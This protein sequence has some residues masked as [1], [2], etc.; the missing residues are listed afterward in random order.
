[1]DLGSLHNDTLYQW[2]HCE[3]KKDAQRIIDRCMAR[4]W[5]HAAFLTEGRW[6]VILSSAVDLQRDLHGKLP[7][8]EF[9]ID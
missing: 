8:L 7:G 1:M 4:G 6:T 3:T 5:F 9:S 2:L